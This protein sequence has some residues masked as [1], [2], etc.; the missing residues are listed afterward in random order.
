M[1]TQSLSGFEVEKKRRITRCLP[2]SSASDSSCNAQLPITLDPKVVL[3]TVVAVSLSTLKP[4]FYSHLNDTLVADLP[5]QPTPG[6]E[7]D[8]PFAAKAF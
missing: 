7:A 5:Q 4:A 6:P 3:S 2:V 8:I 1:R